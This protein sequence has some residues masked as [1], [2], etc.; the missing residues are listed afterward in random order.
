M[1]DY[2]IFTPEIKGYLYYSCTRYATDL[3]YPIGRKK[4]VPDKSHQTNDT[5]SIAN[6]S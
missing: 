6:K 5:Y 3:F 4:S 2:P 1:T